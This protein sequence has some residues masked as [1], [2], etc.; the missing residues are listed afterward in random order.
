MQT[1]SCKRREEIRY[2]EAFKLEVV[3]EVEG[4]GL[5]FDAVSRKYGIQGSTTGSNWV[6]K[7][8]NGSRGKVTRVEKPD[9][10][11]ELKRLKTRVRQ[12]ESA[13][14]DANI[15]AALE[16]AYTRLA[17]QRAGIADVAEFKKK[18]LASRA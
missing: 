15:D 8:G 3:R 5:A 13:L 12:L 1:T 6:R 7:H 4:G 16:R 11:N 2:S 14:A 10:L 9:E 17:C 18:P